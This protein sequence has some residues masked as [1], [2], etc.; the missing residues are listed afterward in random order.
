MKDKDKRERVSFKYNKDADYAFATVI[1]FIK[2]L[3]SEIGKINPFDPRYKDAI[4]VTL[5]KM[6]VVSNEE[7]IR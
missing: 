6:S 7:L 3:Y 2:V 5:P 1:R 4:R